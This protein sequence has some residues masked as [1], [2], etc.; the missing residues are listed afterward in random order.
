[1]K[2]DE[3]KLE[4]KKAL[5]ALRIPVLFVAIALVVKLIEVVFDTSFVTLGV[6]PRDLRGAFGI[7]TSPF[8]HSSWEHLFGNAVP[9]IV[10]GGLFI[11]FNRSNFKEIGFWLYFISGIWLWI[12]GRSSF[13]IGASGVVYALAAYLIT[14]GFVLRN[15]ATLAI[16]FL[17]ILF[18][19]SLIW[20]VLPIKE[21]MSW[22]A[23]LCGAL[24]GVFLA[25]YYGKEQKRKISAVDGSFNFTFDTKYS[26]P[27]KFNYVYK[28]DEK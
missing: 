21:G 12:F 4:I 3:D 9:I 28:E 5:Q 8:I 16:T 1:M 2:K 18:Y 19:G 10:L 22:E 25:I 24:C 6:Y 27:I 14:Y 17:V 23:H 7:I 13:H 11:Y 20:Y 15:K 26:E